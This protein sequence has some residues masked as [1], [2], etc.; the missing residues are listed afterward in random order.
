MARQYG[1]SR[2]NNA[3]REQKRRRL[4]MRYWF[5]AKKYGWGWGLPLTWEGWVFLL[6]WVAITLP[7]TF[8][9]ANQQHLIAASLF[10]MIMIGVLLIICWTK[11]EPPRWRWG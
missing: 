8:W 10:F 7:V 3:R 11:G 1:W 9:L 6:A 5:G 2:H 4:P